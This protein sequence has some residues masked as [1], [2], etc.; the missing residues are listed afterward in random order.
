MNAPVRRAARSSGE[1]RGYEP[2]DVQ[3]SGFM[4]I[5]FREIALTLRKR[6]G[7]IA[8]ITIV[9]TALIALGIFQIQPLY[10]AQAVALMDSQKLNVLDVQSVVTGLSS[11][12]GAI[13][14][15]VQV[16]ESR[17]LIRRVVEQ[18]N[19]VEDPEF[20]SSLRAPSIWR[21]LDPGKWISFLMPSSKS[22]ASSV[23]VEGG[24]EAR[25][26]PVL[27]KVV[28]AVLS[29]LDAE[30][31]GITRA[32]Q[33]NF[34]SESREKAARLAN[35]IANAYVVDQLEAKF[36]AT[37]Q[38]NEWLAGRL[39]DLR[40]KVTSSERAVELYRSQHGLEKSSGMTVTEQQL[41]ELNAQLIL[42]KTNLVE[43]R[44]KYNRARELRR[45]GGSVESVGDVMQSGTIS[46]L[47]QKQAELAREKADLSAKY[48]PRHPA[49][50]N[51]EAQQNDI[52]AQISAE[53]SRIIES[54]RNDVSVA[55]T[56]ARALEDNLKQIKGE[57]GKDNQALVR[58]HDLE[59][60]A[61]ANK[62]VYEAFLGRF[63]ET[64]EQQ[65]LQTPDAR[66]ISEAVVPS[67]PSFPNTKLFVLAGF[68]LSF[69]LG[70]GIAFLVEYFES[71][72]QTAK[73]VEQHLNLPHLVS[74][75]L[76][77]REKGTDGAPL[78]PQEYMFAKPLSAYSE[79]LRSLRSALQFSN[80]DNPPK[81]VLFTSALPNEGKTTTAT[82]FARAAAATGMKTILIDCDLRHPSV[83]TAL[84]RE[85][86]EQGL[87]ELLASRL[88]L[89]NVTINDKSSGMDVILVAKGTAN[90]PDVLGSSQ[91]K[92]L[93]DRLRADYDLVVLDSPPVLPVADARVLSQV[94]DETLFVVRWNQTPLEAARNAVKELRQ[95]NAPIAGAV[96]SMVD[97]SKQAKYG[98]GD[99][100]YYY[101]HYSKYYVD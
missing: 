46:G 20:N 86:A 57:T 65:D 101:S 61:A 92:L 28:S 3:P 99:S 51:I 32:I 13:D 52:Q 70:V 81:V 5:D 84:K 14:S 35:A 58:L 38:A 19:L 1:H 48:G 25:R 18:E 75:P 9:L 63:K 23:A 45:Q 94:A 68:I 88:E 95:Y 73:D 53:V 76:T 21:W 67:S 71:G 87:V 7:L 30:R 24:D 12:A 41:S 10:T 56:R 85:R 64:S 27:E 78:E 83:H 29:H 59:R 97:S 6:M 100:G 90:P 82:S 49:I 8:G 66:I 44:A 36:N 96:L 47:R 60:E 16:L 39:D 74:L 40:Q 2:E 37:K 62:Q 91:M 22:D 79:S 93:L 4:E 33:I 54:L 50:V 17:N 89:K 98:Y 42:A 55:E 34:Q 15:E 77:P 31:R 69:G 11:D 26:D 72:F 43:A 80:V